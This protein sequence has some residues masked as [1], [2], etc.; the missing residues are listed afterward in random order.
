MI[1]HRSP[2]KQSLTLNKRHKPRKTDYRQPSLFEHA[3]C[4][5]QG[6]HE[7]QTYEI[8][9][10]PRYKNRS[11]ARRCALST[12]HHPFV[13]SSRRSIPRGGSNLDVEDKKGER[14][15]SCPDFFDTITSFQQ[16]QLRR[17]MRKVATSRTRYRRLFEERCSSNHNSMPTHNQ[18]DLKNSDNT[19]FSSLADFDDTPEMS[20]T[21]NSR[22]ISERISSSEVPLMRRLRSNSDNF[23]KHLRSSFCR[24]S[25][26]CHN[27]VSMYNQSDLKHSASASSRF[28]ADFHG[29]PAESLKKKNMHIFERISSNGAAPLLRRLNSSGDSLVNYVRTSFCRSSSRNDDQKDNDMHNKSWP[30]RRDGGSTNLMNIVST[31]CRGD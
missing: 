12:I 1:P 6:F 18:S 25:F 17:E 11:V 9:S 14:S 19:S 26:S 4:K 29:T 13:L 16:S 2:N 30:K 27:S 10:P 23:V 24:S 8:I 3:S 20:I 7:S 31:T 22:P 28:F 21:T 5:E 15:K